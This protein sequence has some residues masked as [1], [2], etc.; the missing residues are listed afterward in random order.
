MLVYSWLKPN[1]YNPLSNEENS[2][3]LLALAPAISLIKSME[4]NMLMIE[5]SS[6]SASYRSE[7]NTELFYNR[8]TFLFIQ[9]HIHS[10][11]A[12]IPLCS[13]SN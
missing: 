9:L 4:I 10:Q 5:K 11:N 1:I 2:Q 7:Q 12:R 13:Q 3:L 6:D 8:R